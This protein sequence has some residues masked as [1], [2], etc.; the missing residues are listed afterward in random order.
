MNR[1]DAWLQFVRA[2]LSFV[3]PPQCVLCRRVGALP[4]RDLCV[5]CEVDL[6]LNDRCCAICAAPLQ[7]AATNLVCGTCLRRRPRFDRCFAPYRYAYPL[8]LMIRRFK[9]AGAIP[10]GRV[11]GELVAERLRDEGREHWPDALLPVPLGPARFCKRG[12]NQAIVVAEHIASRLRIPLHTD[13]LV[14]S[15]ETAEQAG[16][17]RR[18]RRKNLRR[19][20][21]LA[22][23]L[24]APHLA[25]I[26]DVVTTGSTAEEV[27]R[28]LKRAGAKRVEVWAIAR[29]ARQRS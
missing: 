28:T 20:F 26:D 5:G 10:E 13:V 18:A 1:V 29:A 7:S 11:L 21:A 22:R 25:V 15:R 24:P 19:A 9:Y 14:R 16:L 12:Y 6:P 2:G 8:D 23:P 3:W 17:D 4:A 27:A